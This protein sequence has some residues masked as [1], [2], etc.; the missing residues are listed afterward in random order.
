MQQASFV[1][2]PRSA[3][4]RLRAWAILN[5]GHQHRLHAQ[6]PV[7]PRTLAVQ[8]HNGQLSE[9][10]A[11]A[12]QTALGPEA[13]AFFTGKAD[14]LRDVAPADKVATHAAT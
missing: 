8:L 12:L 14:V 4:R 5:C 1:P 3:G 7:S 11:Q 2:I 13:W 9:Q 10:V 6:L